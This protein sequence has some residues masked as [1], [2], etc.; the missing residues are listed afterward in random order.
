MATWFDFVE[1]LK[2]VPPTEQG[3]WL[4]KQLQKSLKEIAQ[5]YAGANVILY[6]SAFL[7]RQSASPPSIIISPED[8]N[9]FM[10]VVH[11]MDYSKGLVLILHT[12]GGAVTAVETIVSYLHEK[13]E[14]IIAIVPVYA[15]SGGT[16]ISLS[17]DKIILGRQ[18]QLG[19]IDPQFTIGNRSIPARAIVE[20]FH[21]AR[22]DIEKDTRNAHMWAPIL[23]N[24][25]VSLLP[26]A[27]DALRYSEL[28]IKGWLEKRMF[29]SEKAAAKKAAKVVEFFNARTKDIHSHGQ[30]I[31]FN[32]LKELKLDVKM[33]EEDQRLQESVLSTYHLMTVLF[34]RGGTTKMIVND[35]GKR[36]LKIEQVIAVPASQM[37]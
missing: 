18:S 30:R 24:F 15:M 5:I 9:G 32:K 7:Q 11:N 20:T 17:C 8:I 3:T 23:Q 16:M 19:P 25:G 36:W 12:P 6:A 22:K 10:T 37:S 29:A 1:N 35:Q 14:N 34:E 4:D 13:F 21:K 28:L 27:E 33:L 26:E 2:K 31:D